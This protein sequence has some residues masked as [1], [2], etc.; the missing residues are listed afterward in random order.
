[1]KQMERRQL[2]YKSKGTE[3]KKSLYECKQQSQQNKKK[4]PVS[5]FFPLIAV[6]IDT[7]A[8]PLLSN[9]SMN[10]RY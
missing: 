1:M 8:Q 9:I 5:K 2:A 6:V 7:T 3:S 4:L 10:F